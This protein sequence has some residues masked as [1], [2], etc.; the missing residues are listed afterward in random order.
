MY[1]NS[2]V[3]LSARGLKHPDRDLRLL[4]H[5]CVT[6]PTRV[7]RRRLLADLELWLSQELP[8]WG[9]E[10]LA[11]NFPSHLSE[12][13]AE[14]ISWLY[15]QGR[16]RRDA[17]ETLNS[18][19]QQFGWLRPQLHQPWSLIRTWENLE[20]VKHHP[21]LP[22]K[23]LRAMLAVCIAWDWPKMGM[24]LALGF[25][26]LLRPI[27]ALSLRRSDVVM[28]FESLEDAIIYIRIRSPK[29]RFRGAT[30]QHVRVDHPDAIGFVNTYLPGIP[31]WQH[32]WV[33]SYAAFR[34][35]FDCLQREVT[36]ATPFLPS[37]LRPGGATFLFRLWQENLPRLQWRGRWRSFRM[38][39]TY[40]QELG[41]AE[42]LARF[43][44]TVLA[45][46]SVLDSF[47]VSLL[48]SA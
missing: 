6:G 32:I 7:L 37:S 25:F 15:S 47:F 9:L 10:D 39:E 38:L 45:R 12:W 48:H 30:S 22:F 14:Y 31:K 29:T 17:A 27:E 20:P 8:E 40:V 43:S 44:P 41:V 35:R 28:P 13:L 2:L 21:P 4:R 3:V 18:L 1:C 19:V 42:A 46:I 5:G 33:G 36:L 11:R 34:S 23:V 24:I 26:A 16:S